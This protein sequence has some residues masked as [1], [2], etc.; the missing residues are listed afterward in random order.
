MS[1]NQNYDCSGGCSCGSC[2]Q[3]YEYPTC[4]PDYSPVNVTNSTCPTVE[5]STGGQG[6]AA[7]GNNSSVN[8]SVCG[9]RPIKDSDCCCKKGV[10]KL[11]NYLYLRSLDTTTPTINLCLHSNIIPSDIV[12]ATSCTGSLMS[13]SSPNIPLISITPDLIKLNND[14][15]SLCSISVILFSFANGASDDINLKKEFFYTPQC[16]CCCDCGPGVAQALYL[17]GLGLD[18]TIFLQDTL[19]QAT[20]KTISIASLSPIKLIAID[21]DIAIFST[22]ISNEI[23]YFGIPTCKI[24]K[25][26]A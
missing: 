3:G 12:S 20:D 19:M 13:V 2:S 4:S 7:S 15:V 14:R 24:A 5:G 1:Y 10:E 25:F 17:N 16:K 18:Y 22:T 6:G 8:V 26:T 21:K 11:L 23:T 9:T